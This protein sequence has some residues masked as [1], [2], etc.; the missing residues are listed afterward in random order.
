MLM[1]IHHFRIYS[2]ESVDAHGPR[3][4]ICQD[5]LPEYLNHEAS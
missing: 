5:R 4:Q 3:D 1:V 2:F